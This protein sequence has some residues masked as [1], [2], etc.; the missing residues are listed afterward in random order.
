MAYLSSQMSARDWILSRLLNESMGDNFESKG[1]DDI[2][3]P[4][5]PQLASVF[6][7]TAINGNYRRL[8]K[9]VARGRGPTACVASDA[10]NLSATTPTNTRS[11]RCR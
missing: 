3:Q 4:G 9:L 6:V 11:T 1:D 5:S 10:K 7:V 2:H 8:L